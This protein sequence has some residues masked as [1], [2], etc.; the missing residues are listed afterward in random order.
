MADESTSHVTLVREAGQYGCLGRCLPVREKTARQAHTPLNKVCMRRDSY[1]ACEAPQE[2]EAAYA[3]ECCQLGQRYVR[4]WSRIQALDRLCNAGRCATGRGSRHTMPPQ[5]AHQGAK[6]VLFSGKAV[7]PSG[8]KACKQFGELACQQWIARDRTHDLD[9]AH[10]LLSYLAGHNG[11]VEI[12]HPPP[13]RAAINRRT[14]VYLA[15]VRHNYVAD[16]GADG[17]NAAP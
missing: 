10:K 11:R 17:S 14:V 1:F 5:Q 3:R 13:P 15:R 2:L 7:R 4:V 8:R 12:N 16:C 9:R 6:Q